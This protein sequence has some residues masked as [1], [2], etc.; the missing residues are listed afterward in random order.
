MMTSRCEA[1]VQSAFNAMFITSF[2]ATRVWRA[3]LEAIALTSYR[4]LSQ[5]AAGLR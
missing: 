2:R 1:A 4:P 3:G 5:A